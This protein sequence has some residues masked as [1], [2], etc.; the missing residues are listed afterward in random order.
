MLNNS[1]HRIALEYDDDR[2]LGVP[3]EEEQINIV[4]LVNEN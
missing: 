4:L 2:P 3:G 1:H